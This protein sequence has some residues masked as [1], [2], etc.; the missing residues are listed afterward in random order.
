MAIL[1]I[2]TDRKPDRGGLPQISQDTEDRG[3]VNA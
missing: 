1:F 2:Y 3:N